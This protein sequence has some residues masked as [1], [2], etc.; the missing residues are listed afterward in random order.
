MGNWAACFGIVGFWGAGRLGV[1]SVGPGGR[2][3]GLPGTRLEGF[4]GVACG[5]KVVG[6]VGGTL[7]G[8][9]GAARGF[10]KLPSV[11]VGNRGLSG[12]VLIVDR[13]E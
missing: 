5:V 7:R 9:G 6:G 1:M 3:A 13:L 11:F 2:G 10:S 12:G 4:A 8:I